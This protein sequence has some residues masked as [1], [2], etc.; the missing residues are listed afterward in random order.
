MK[1]MRALNKKA[2]RIDDYV[3][4]RTDDVVAMQDRRRPTSAPT[5]RWV[6]R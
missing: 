4:S 5:F 2:G 1:H 6:A 3:T